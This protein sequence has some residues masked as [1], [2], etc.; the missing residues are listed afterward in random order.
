MPRMSG[1]YSH[2][3]YYYYYYYCYNYCYYYYYCCC[4]RFPDMPCMQRVYKDK[5]ALVHWSAATNEERSR[6]R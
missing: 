5:K 6:S 2:Y 3:Y 1:N 4:V